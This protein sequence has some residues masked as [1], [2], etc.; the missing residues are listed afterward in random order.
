M[1]PDEELKKKYPH[2]E[3]F[4]PYTEVI[5][6]ES[7]RGKVLVSTGFL[8]EQLKQ[9]L[10]AFML[11]SQQAEDLVEGGN[12]PLGTLSSR[13]SACFAL[14]LIN[15][16]EHDDLHLIRKIRNDFAHD[17]HTTFETESVVNRCRELHY[18]AK[19]VPGEKNP[20]RPEGKFHSAAVDLIMRFTNRPFYVSKHKRTSV[21][22]PR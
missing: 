12:A 22:W 3:K 14:G 15:Q 17:I 20:I 7:A 9:I 13:I 5:D 4:W 6:K 18:S 16:H 8:E 1:I 2:L 10:L 11:E 21:N 19:D